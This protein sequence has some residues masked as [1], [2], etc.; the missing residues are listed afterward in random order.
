MKPDIPVI[1]YHTVGVVEPRWRWSFLTTP[2]QVFENQV[3]YL[4][5]KGYAAITL[6]EL[7]LYRGGEGTLPARPVLFTFD[8]GYLDN[9]VYAAP[10]LKKYGMRGTI[11]VNPEFIDPAQ[12]RRLSLEDVR[13][14]RCSLD[15]LPTMGF[16]SW[17]EMQVM[18]SAG[19]M[20]IQSHAMTHTWYPSGPEIV[21]FRHP[22]D[23]YVWM[24]WNQAPE[25]KWAYL[26]PGKRPEARYGEPVYRH[27]KSLA[28]CRFFPDPAVADHLAEF[29]AGKGEAFF[30][31][32]NWREILHREADSCV[33][34][35][36]SNGRMESE[37]ECL[38]RLEWELGESKRLLEQHLHKDIDFLCWPG[39]G[40]SP[41]AVR[42]ARTYYKGSTLSSRDSGKPGF[43]EGGH[44]RI[45]RFGV[46][47]LARGSRHFYPGGR[48]LYH[49][50]R[51]FQGSR[52]HRLIRQFLKLFI[53]LRGGGLR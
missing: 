6:R 22:G 52:R 27:Q 4:K 40:Y 23:E 39:G 19:T 44:L 16:L 31:L 29:A 24:E 5:K 42:I 14:G 11:F 26:S 48:Y 7:Y 20:D 10:I 36:I 32:G 8:D 43:D 41:E 33:S 13:S 3:A 53:M 49:Y 46:P 51:E 9:W 2:W 15:D 1:M 25:R 12:E 37:G 45:R 34:V 30:S 47:T 17:A 21:D 28:G 18:E 50:L 35:A 38:K